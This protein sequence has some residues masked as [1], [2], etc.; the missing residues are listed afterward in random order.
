M[1]F[2]K[3]V[4]DKIP[5]IIEKNGRTP[6]YHVADDAEFERE[7][8]KKLREEVDEYLENPSPE[9]MI[10]ILEVVIAI[11]GIKNYDKNILEELRVKKLAERGGFSGRI[12]LDESD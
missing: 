12:I 1:K 7:L 2:N 3:L 9:E 10:D 4:R 6:V 5:E 11:Y 8:L